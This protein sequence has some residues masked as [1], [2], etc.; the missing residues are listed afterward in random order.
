MP[1]DTFETIDAAAVSRPTERRVG[2]TPRA[3]LD[4]VEGDDRVLTI[5][6][7]LPSHAA[8]SLSEIDAIERYLSDILDVVLSSR[9]PT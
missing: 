9:S 1:A 3:A 6:D 8:I 2:E 7:D 5:T 4:G